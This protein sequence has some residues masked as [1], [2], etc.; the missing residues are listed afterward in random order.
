MKTRF[1][2]L[3]MMGVLGIYVYTSIPLDTLQNVLINLMV[4][5]V[6]TIL[7]MHTMW[8]MSMSMRKDKQKADKE[9][10]LERPLYNVLDDSGNLL[11]MGE[12][13]D[14]NEKMAMTIGELTAEIKQRS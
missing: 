14:I 5:A 13:A 9:S 7:V 1:L 8:Y 12:Y 11:E 10:K 2:L 6:T 3:L 4:S